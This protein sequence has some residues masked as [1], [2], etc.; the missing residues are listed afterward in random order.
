MTLR[1]HLV[2]KLCAAFLA[3]AA[4]GVAASTPDKSV[5]EYVKV[6]P[7]HGSSDWTLYHF[8]SLNA[9]HAR[10]VSRERGLNS[11]CLV[12]PDATAYAVVWIRSEHEEPLSDAQGKGANALIQSYPS[13]AILLGFRRS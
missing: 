9:E 4:I 11:K 6:I 1:F 10:F 3:C 8:Q 5:V 13:D 7:S 2:A 12:V